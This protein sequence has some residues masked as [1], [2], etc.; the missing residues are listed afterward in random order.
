MANIAKL[1]VN[2]NTYDI[3]DSSARSNI[4]SEYDSTATYVIGDIVTY[5]DDVYICT[6]DVTTAESFDN[7]KWTQKNIGDIIEDIPTAGSW[8]YNSSTETLTYA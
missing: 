2:G 6:T 4:A 8:T 3:K 7:S 5:N 1:T